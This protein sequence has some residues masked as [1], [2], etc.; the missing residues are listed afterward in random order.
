LPVFEHVDETLAGLDSIRRHLVD[1][2][3][4]PD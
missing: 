2:R 1:A 4:L 3:A